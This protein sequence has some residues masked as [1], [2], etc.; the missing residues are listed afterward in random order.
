M[1]ASHW[2]SCILLIYNSF[3]DVSK[4]CLVIVYKM[5]YII[6]V[7]IRRLIS[8]SIKYYRL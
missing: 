2:I 6:T 5:V 4:I 1:K 8:H 7:V 3:S